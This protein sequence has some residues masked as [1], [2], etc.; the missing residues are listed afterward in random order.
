[1]TESMAGGLLLLAVIVPPFVVIAGAI[2]LAIASGR[3]RPA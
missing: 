1:M 3:H 2:A